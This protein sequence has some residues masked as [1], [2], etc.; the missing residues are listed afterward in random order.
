WSSC[1]PCHLKYDFILKLADIAQEFDH[2]FD[3]ANITDHL[4]TS[5]ATNKRPKKKKGSNQEY[6]KH[7]EDQPDYILKKIYDTYKLDYYLFGFELPHF[8]KKF[9][10][11][12][13]Y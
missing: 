11:M 8:L 3:V 4:Q 1:N 13:H 12:D 5:I 6:L 2:V 9:E 7:Y 10:N